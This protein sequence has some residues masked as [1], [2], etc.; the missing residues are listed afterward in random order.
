MHDRQIVHRKVPKHVHVVLKEA[1]VHPRGIVIA[2]LAE[3]AGADDLVHLADGGGVDERMVDGENQSPLRGLVDQ[4]PGLVGGRGDR[5]FDEDVLSRLQRRHGDQVRSF[6]WVGDLV[7][8]NLRAAT[9]PRATGQA[10]NAASGIRVTINE[11]AEGMLK[12][13][14]T[15]EPRLRV[16]H[17]DPLVGDIMEF[18]VSNEKIR[19]E[20][21]IEFQSDFWGTLGTALADVN[22]FLGKPQVELV[23]EGSPER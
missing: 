23:E 21:G 20:L 16:E 4:L 18:D 3:V 15:G 12:I 22:A 13:L 10:Y 11:L 5:L 2:H 1:E 14:D 19:R 8:A 6:T 9:D 17:G 7:E